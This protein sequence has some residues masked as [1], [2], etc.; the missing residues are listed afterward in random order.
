MKFERNEV[1]TGL[2][3]IV[4]AGVLLGV[5]LLLSA[6]GFFKAL[7]HYQIFFDNAAGLKP[8]APVMVA[9][10]QIGQV[11][12]IEAPV[13]MA[14]RPAKYPEDEVL[15]TVR[16]DSHA[17]VYRNATPR[18]IQN[19][20]LGE[21]VIDFVGGTEESG[22]A[23]NGYIFVGER[24]P[25][26]NSALPKIL[27]VIE[28]VAST[29]T[30]TLSELR[31]TIDTL[32]AV[33]GQE[34]DLRAALTKLR[35]TADNISSLTA[36]DGSLGHTLTNLQDFT[37]KLKSD[38]GP[39]MSTLNNLEKTTDDINKDNRVE[40][41]LANFEQASAR[42]DTAAK[43]ANALLTSLTPSFN[44]SAVNL[45]QMTDTLKR[46]PWRI[47]WPTTKKYDVAVPQAGVEVPSGAASLRD[48]K[49]PT[50]NHRRASEVP[51][52]ASTRAVVRS[53]PLLTD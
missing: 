39:L 25:D 22:D 13:A 43:Q 2:L 4:T 5:I 7:S 38:D 31:K 15:I 6:P 37:T 42:A 41:M 27:S 18:M 53:G 29:A 14:R 49:P 19:G 40:K 48:A 44:Q 24:V 21:P 16:I 50:R 32:N 1:T 36:S 17:I 26:L 8:G 35:L 33:F 20:L 11:A 47:V 52:G 51:S 46:Q 10:H 34:G 12:L 30:L 28:P 3:V 9:G 23:Q 45:S